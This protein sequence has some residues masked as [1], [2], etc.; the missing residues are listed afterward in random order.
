MKVVSVIPIA[1]GVLKKELDY[2]SSKEISI[3][4]IVTVLVRKKETHALV[5]QVDDL[6]NKKTSLKNSDFGLK[7]VLN[8]HSRTPLSPG[9]IQAIRD[10]A[11][12][13][14]QSPGAIL[15]RLIPKEI[16]EKKLVEK[17]THNDQVN[18]YSQEP[19]A[20]QAP[21]EDR[22]SFYKTY[23]REC[24]AKKESLFICVPGSQSAE[25]FE[26]KLSKG[27][28]SYLFTLH[29][30]KSKKKIQEALSAIKKEE[31]PVIIIGT[32]A[33]LYTIDN[34]IR[35]LILENESSPMYKTF[36]SP[37]FD[38]RTFVRF[39]AKK[40]KI[41]LILADTI[42]QTE[43][44]WEFK[45]GIIDT[46][47]PPNFRFPKKSERMMIDTSKDARELKEESWSAISTELEGLIRKQQEAKG[48]TFLFALRKGLSPFTACGDCQKTLLC[49]K[50]KTPLTLYKQK[51]KDFLFICNS[52]NNTVNPLTTCPYCNSWNLKPLGIGTEKIKEELAELFPEAPVFIL[53][54]S[55]AKTK[56]Q[57]KNIIKE[58]EATPGAIL[59]GTE[60]ALH[61]EISP[62]PLVGIT[63]FDSLFA[64]PS[65]RIH[66]R[67]L[68]LLMHLE[69]RTSNTFAIQTKNIDAAILKTFKDNTFIQYYNTEITQREAFD[70]PP[71]ATL[72]KII[73]DAKTSKTEVKKI[74]EEFFSPYNPS[75]F[76]AKHKNKKVPAILLKIPRSEWDISEMRISA[77]LQKTLI[78]LPPNWV[79]HVDPE[80][81]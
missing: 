60:Q 73:P 55:H 76:I 61:Y 13:H 41:K 67:I 36:V 39:F 29:G 80:N 14:I 5:T 50:C 7:K 23:I 35:T 49:D 46:L 10:T 33:F 77:L 3:G 8:I 69:E 28:G 43:T 21:K 74:A 57:A 22:L 71:F 2:F 65:F 9:F 32:P 51:N 4:D 34:S 42:M 20:F 40:E 54:Q 17:K 68:H 19:L 66:E 59:I 37:L 78:E 75:L 24:F 31:H 72:I 25:L 18:E 52:C 45:Q 47:T 44:I 38:I 27:V 63:S 70:Y 79:I 1:K 53:D 30:D 26:E 58:F 56:T 15:S 16:L 11:K 12:Y 81:T 62:V 48:R 64:I 6:A